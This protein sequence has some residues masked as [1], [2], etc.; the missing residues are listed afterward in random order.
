MICLN[1]FLRALCYQAVQDKEESFDCL[2]GLD[3]RLIVRQTALHSLPSEQPLFD[4]WLYEVTLKF[5]HE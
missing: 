4:V 1:A 2:I 5:S 3:R